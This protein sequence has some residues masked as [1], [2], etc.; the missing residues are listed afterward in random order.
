MDT[1]LEKL[2]DLA[3]ADGV[4]TDK[5]RQVLARKAQ[6]LGVDHD[7]FE[8]VL[9]GKLH[10]AQK[11][12]STYQQSTTSSKSQ[13]EGDARKCPSCGAPA[14]S[15]AATCSTCGH[16]FRNTSANTSVQ[17]LFDAL[18]A[19]PLEAHAS[20]ISNY[21]V[22]NTKED[23]LEFLSIAIGNCA[24]LTFEQKQTYQDKGFLSSSYRP[25]LAH[26]EAEIRAWQSKFSTVVQKARILFTDE[27]ATRQ[28]SDFEKRYSYVVTSESKEA[29]KNFRNVFIGLVA[30]LALIFGLMS[31]GESSHSGDKV[32]ESERLEAIVDQVNRDIE[33]NN[34]RAALVKASGLK[35]EYSDSWSHYDQEKKS[36]DEKRESMVQAIKEAQGSQ[37]ANQ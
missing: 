4:L 5:E 3:L 2:I 18:Q 29:K 35:W 28:I 21:P 13:K 22:P 25:E 19:A 32:R 6:E 31:I 17:K 27:N 7:E 8:M 37:N 33:A 24:P 20:I 9:E 10:L 14:L 16:E 15:F 11:L 30:F 1:Q 34:L 26:R 12:P 23:I 36:W